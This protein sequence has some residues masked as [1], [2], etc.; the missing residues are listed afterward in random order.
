MPDEHTLTDEIAQPAP[1]PKADSVE[2][3]RA[4]LTEL[5]HA[6]STLKAKLLAKAPGAWD[7]DA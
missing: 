3:L 6:F 4:D 2:Q 7:L 1:E 5:Q